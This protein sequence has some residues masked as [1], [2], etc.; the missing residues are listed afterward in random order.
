MH[1]VENIE[2][3]DD[4]RKSLD[5]LKQE[6]QKWIDSNFDEWRNQSL[7]A[8]S[9]GE[10][11]YECP[12]LTFG[13]RGFNRFSCFRLK[14]DQPVV[15]FEKDGRQLMLVTFKPTLV[16]FCSDVREFEELSFR[17][18]IELRQTALFANK[19]MGYARKLQQIANFHNTIGDRMIPCVRPVMLK[20]A[21]ELSNLVRSESVAWNDEESVERYVSKLQVAV[22]NL[23]R[24]N[25]VLTEYH[26]K[27]KSIVS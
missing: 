27:A 1:L 17:I 23:S 19:F 26:E 12:Y 21:L 15:E 10:L 8:I 6:T 13:H 11:T 14:D 24:D 7:S 4:V 20:N 25:S 18:P 5:N 3:Y 9:R 2:G 22:H 16:M